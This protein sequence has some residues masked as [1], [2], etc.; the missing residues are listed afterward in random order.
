MM[1]VL[2]S[3]DPGKTG[4]FA[5]FWEGNLAHV[6]DPDKDGNLSLKFADVL[7]EY[8]DMRHRVTVVIERVNG[9]PGQ[10]A[11]AS[12]NFGQG[13]GELLGV[14]IGLGV[15]PV[16]IGPA[17]WKWRMGLRGVGKA[18]SVTAAAARW[19]ADFFNLVKHN[20][21]AEAALLGQYWLEEQ[22]RS[23]AA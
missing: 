23:A 19:G 6:Y 15:I 20:G 2:I 13:Y 21:R 8:L 4:G 11:P 22:Q 17:T 9:V 1:Q 7:L 18:A 3:V 10:S 14:C 12:F 5:L 16:L